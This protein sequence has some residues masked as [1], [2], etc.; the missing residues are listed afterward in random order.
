M[1]I[2][3]C[4]DMPKLTIITINY[5]SL[6]LLRNS[7]SAV[8]RSQ[9]KDSFDFWVVDNGSEENPEILKKEFP[10]IQVICN[11][12]NLG[13]AKANNIVLRR[14]LSEYALLLNPD[15]IVGSDAIQKLI[16]FMDSHPE[17]GVVG[18]KLIRPD[19]TYDATSKFGSITPFSI[20]A[21]KLQLVKIFPSSVRLGAFNLSHLD[22]NQTS[23]VE[24]ITGA[25]M[26]VRRAA[27]EKVG[28]LDESYFLGI[29]DVDWCYRIS[30]SQNEAGTPY[31]IY[32]Y[33]EAVVVH[34][35]RQ[36]RMKNPN[37]STRKFHRGTWLF[38]QKFQTNHH[39]PLFNHLVR[40]GLLLSQY[41]RIFTGR[42]FQ[43]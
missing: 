40:G 32:Y 28:L 29:E 15:T 41:G 11:Q 22:P 39:H 8:Y 12:E 36:S 25:S 9:I 10:L 2:T 18:P 35:G 5:N 19:G 20:L 43:R 30:K 16:D 1:A 3:E 27:T 31:S 33:P 7:I 23:K 14:L 13:F 17:A 42:L 24:A 38:Y 4:Q 37:L 6:S 34:L 26:M 21:K